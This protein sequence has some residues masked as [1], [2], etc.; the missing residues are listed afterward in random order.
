LIVAA[1]PS[2]EAEAGSPGEARS[3]ILFDLGLFLCFFD[4]F[5]VFVD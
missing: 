2:L 1:R 4:V 5:C 3:E